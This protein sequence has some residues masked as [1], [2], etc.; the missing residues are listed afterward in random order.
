MFVYLYVCMYVYMY[1]C[2]YVCMYACMHS[3]WFACMHV[4]VCACMSL[5]VRA[6]CAPS[7]GTMHLWLRCLPPRGFASE[8]HPW[9]SH[10]LRSQRQHLHHPTILPITLPLAIPILNPNLIT[11]RKVPRSAL[12]VDRKARP[13]H[14]IPCCAVPV[15]AQVRLSPHGHARHMAP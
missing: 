1:V 14:S 3:H 8:A 2:M 9:L 6:A 11:Q 10:P 15:R 5:S 12:E 4:N 7:I 13:L